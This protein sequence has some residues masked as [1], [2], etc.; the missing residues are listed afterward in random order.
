MVVVGIK[1]AVHRYCVKRAN[2]NECSNIPHWPGVSWSVEGAGLV[3]G[4]WLATRGPPRGSDALFVAEA[5]VLTQTA[6]VLITVITGTMCLTNV[7]PLWP[8]RPQQVI[9]MVICTGILCNQA[10]T[11]TLTCKNHAPIPVLSNWSWYFLPKPFLWN[12]FQSRIP[13]KI[14]RSKTFI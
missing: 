7:Y 8:V 2:R 9:L 11:D 6:D 4:A 3:C 1:M 13:S 5:R 12:S 10:R 14:F